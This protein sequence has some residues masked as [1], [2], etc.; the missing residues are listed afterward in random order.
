MLDLFIGVFVVGMVFSFYV[1]H[2]RKIDKVR[3]N[4]DNIFKD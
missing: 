1:N 2:K 4:L 3:D